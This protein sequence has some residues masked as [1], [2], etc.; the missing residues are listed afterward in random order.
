MPRVPKAKPK[1]TAAMKISKRKTKKRAQTKRVKNFDKELKAIYREDGKMPNLTKLDQNRGSRLTRFLI[2][3]II[4]SLVLAAVAWAGFLFFNPFAGQDGQ[5]LEVLFDGPTAITSGEEVVYEIEYNN[6]G[7]VPLAALDI[8]LNIPETFVVTKMDPEP[9]SGNNTWTVGSL[10]K[11]G[12]GTIELTGTVLGSVNTNSTIQ[13][14]MTYRPANFNADFQ[15]IETYEFLIDSSVLEAALASPAK[16]VPGDQI[17]YIYELT[18]TGE[19]TLYDVYVDVIAPN[20]WLTTGAVPELDEEHFRWVIS[21]LAADEKVELKINGSFSADIQD[22]QELTFTSYFENGDSLALVQTSDKAQTDV[23]GTDLQAQ[24][25]I[26]GSNTDLDLNPGD[27]LRISLNYNNAGD[28]N[29]GNVVFTLDLDSAISGKALPIDWDEARL[30]D[31]YLDQST[32]EITWGPISTPELSSLAVG[33]EGVIDVTLPIISEID[34]DTYTD[35]INLIL[36]SSLATVGELNSPRDLSS[37]PVEITINSDLTAAAEAR[38]YDNEG[39]VIGSGPIPPTVDQIT[40]YQIIWSINN[41][42]HQMEDVE[43]STT[44]P[45][46]V[47]WTGKTSTEIGQLSYDPESRT[48]RWQT[49]SLPTTV[50]QVSAT[51]ELAISPSESDVGTFVKLTNRTSVSAADANTENEINHSLDELTTDLINDEHA[52][53]QGVVVEE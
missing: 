23:L 3:F 20:N 43:L 30:S 19:Q 17:E 53:G 42:L 45:L 38:Y 44:L 34:A 9:T 15:D 26:N 16:A 37:A 8:K 50:N 5:S 31:G 33:D 7:R 24:L 10:K 27:Y 32:H 40:A 21:Q 35:Q 46:E 13:A 14:I 41:S 11:G 2:R 1:K 4:I 52:E 51:Y 6:N 28:E 36:K 29:L 22:L 48:V 47:S 18:N 25:I 49:D 12:K 39:D